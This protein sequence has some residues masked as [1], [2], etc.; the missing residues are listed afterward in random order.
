MTRLEKCE[1]AKLKGYTYNPSTGEIIGPRGKIIKRISSGYCVIGIY[2]N[3]V[4]YD[5]S[6]HHYAWYMTYDNVD[7]IEIDHINRIKTD[8][9]ISNLR[10][11]NKSQNQWNVEYKG[12]YFNKVLNKWRARIRV[13]NERI[14]LG[15]FKTEE[16]AR[17][18]YLQAKKKYHII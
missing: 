14:S 18:S 10:N 15:D 5:L 3:N 8:N 13:N 6:A 4:K 9:R 16:E 7:I 12:Y 2:S 17:E 11:V 1:L